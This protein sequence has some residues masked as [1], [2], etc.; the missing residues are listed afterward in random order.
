MRIKYVQSG[1][2]ELS[3]KYIFILFFTRH[4]ALPL[5]PASICLSPSSWPGLL[6]ADLNLLTQT[7]PLG[8]GPRL[9]S[10]LS[11]ESLADSLG[12]VAILFSTPC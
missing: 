10:T 6:K 1:W 8:Q 7:L 11:L 9:T 12:P 3:A 2:Q 5:C 4:P